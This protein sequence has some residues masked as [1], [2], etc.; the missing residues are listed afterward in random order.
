M[1]ETRLLV[2][3]GC[4]SC[5]HCRKAISAVVGGGRGAGL[6]I[7]VIGVIGGTMFACALE[8]ST[9]VSTVQRSSVGCNSGL[10]PIDK[11]S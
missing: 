7:S 11:S 4:V 1:V 10:K 6:G 9:I 2:I 8:A 5:C 3:N